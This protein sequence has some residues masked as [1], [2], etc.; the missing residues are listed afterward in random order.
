MTN[1]TFRTLI[2]LPD[3]SVP[4]THPSHPNAYDAHPIGSFVMGI[5]PDTTS[6]YKAI[7]KGRLKTKPP[8]LAKYL[9]TFDDDEDQLR[10]MDVCDVVEWPGGQ[11]DR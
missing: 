3:I 1:T 10:E 9:V 2:P 8:G 5:F 6:F 11:H 4:P 7:V